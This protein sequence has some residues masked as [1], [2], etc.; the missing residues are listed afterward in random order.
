VHVDLKRAARDADQTGMGITDLLIGG[1]IGCWMVV[2]FWLVAT[3]VS[4][5]T[6]KA[7]QPVNRR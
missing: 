5:L 1:F 3:F 4:D 7:Q 6:E 2:S